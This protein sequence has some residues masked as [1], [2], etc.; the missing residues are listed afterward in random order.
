[1]QLSQ[2]DQGIDAKTIQN[3]SARYLQ[4]AYRVF[5][6]RQAF[7]Q[8]QESVKF[9]HPYFSQAELRETLSQRPPQARNKVRPKYRY[10]H[11][12][13]QTDE[14]ITMYLWPDLLLFTLPGANGLWI[15]NIRSAG[16][17]YHRLRRGKGRNRPCTG[18][19][20]TTQ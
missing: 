5:Q 19:H 4:S 3:H 2:Y 13:G 11:G 17:A 9:P 1:M 7:K 15:S 14:Y 20:C 10:A 6:C 8:F 18:S 12:G 16:M